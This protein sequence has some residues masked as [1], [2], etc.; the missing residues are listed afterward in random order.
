MLT[1]WRGSKKKNLRFEPNQVR[2]TIEKVTRN[3]FG[4]DWMD[5]IELEIRHASDWKDGKR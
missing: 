4:N 3:L 2:K 5:V 1:S